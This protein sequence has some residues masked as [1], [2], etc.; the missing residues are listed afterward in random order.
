MRRAWVLL[1]AAFWMLAGTAAVARQVGPNLNGLKGRTLP[2]FTRKQT[3]TTANG[4]VEVWQRGADGAQL[5]IEVIPRANLA[6]AEKRLN[7]VNSRI[8]GKEPQNEEMIFRIATS[9][10]NLSWANYRAT[11]HIT[12]KTYHYWRLQSGTLVMASVSFTG[13][14][15]SFDAARGAFIAAKRAAD[16]TVKALGL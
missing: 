9:G 11:N 3:K 4:V 5:R 16:S 14:K 10:N 7:A 8:S 6:L 1:F 12:Y 15:P 2:G 13:G